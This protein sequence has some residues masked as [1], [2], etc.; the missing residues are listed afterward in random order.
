MARTHFER[1]RGESGLSVALCG[2][3]TTSV[4]DLHSVVD[5]KLCVRRLRMDSNGPDAARA[6]VE[7][8]FVPGPDT[9]YVRPDYPQPEPLQQM[10]VVTPEVWRRIQCQCGSCKV[11]RWHENADAMWFAR[12]HSERRPASDL[13]RRRF[14]SVKSAL[15]F[16]VT[17]RLYGYPTKSVS[18]SVWQRLKLGAY[19]SGGTGFNVGEDAVETAKLI[20]DALEGQFVDLPDDGRVDFAKYGLD[21]VDCMRLL[22]A[23][24]VGLPDP[25]RQGHLFFESAKQLGK[26]LNVSSAIVGS[27]VSRGKE[28]VRERLQKEGLM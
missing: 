21:H 2:I 27:V 13:D 9:R 16:W 4:T 11:C 28:A 10:L 23:R 12:P 3:M 26:P 15:T 17:V 25:Q 19:V 6:Y 8:L 1:E 18:E 5:C 22:I 14:P 24:V 7:S 20:D